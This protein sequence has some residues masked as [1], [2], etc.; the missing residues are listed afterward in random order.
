M[1]GRKEEREAKGRG[2]S[3]R[4]E[5]RGRQKQREGEGGG[6]RG[7][8]GEE[9]GTGEALTGEGSITQLG[10]RRQFRVTK[11]LPSQLGGRRGR[12]REGEGEEG[13]GKG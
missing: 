10:R 1:R 4:R 9:R 11:F 5:V 3:K 6:G 13:L 2:N 8:M 7:E 12:P